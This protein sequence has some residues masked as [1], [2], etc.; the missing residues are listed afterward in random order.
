M[1]VI[2]F[3]LLS[4]LSPCFLNIS[5]Y[6][7]LTILKAF[8]C[9]FFFLFI[10]MSSKWHSYYFCIVY[11]IWNCSFY[12]HL[13]EYTCGHKY[14]FITAGSVM[15]T[16]EKFVKSLNVHRPFPLLSSC[17]I[18]WKKTFDIL[19][20]NALTQTSWVRMRV[21]PVPHFHKVKVL[22]IM[23]RLRQHSEILCYRFGEYKG[24]TIN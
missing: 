12:T 4:S 15:C 13:H 24:T 21:F 17:I 16:E 9:F 20:L 22:Y 1:S 7:I 14:I 19:S 18:L 3:F 11:M 23:H 8:V 10:I 6:F 2:F 5:K